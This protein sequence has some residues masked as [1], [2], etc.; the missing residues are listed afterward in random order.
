M[1]TNGGDNPMSELVPFFVN[2]T[3]EGEERERFQQAL[4]ASPALRLEVEQE[5][6]LQTK[7]KASIAHEMDDMSPPLA[8]D[9]LTNE[10]AD[11]SGKADSQ[12]ALHTALSALNPALWKPG[13]TLASGDAHIHA[14]TDVGG[15]SI[16][17]L[18]PPSSQGE[19]IIA[20]LAKEATLGELLAL[21]RQEKLTPL[22]SSE[23]GVFDFARINGGKPD[24]ALLERLQAHALIAQARWG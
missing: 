22:E 20:E 24:D 13:D 16:R 3:L 6:A 15:R 12:Q 18:R 19:A 10:G 2:G 14:G 7:I 1:N 17:I 4:K 9:V 23:F 5:V 11:H 21:V 8:M